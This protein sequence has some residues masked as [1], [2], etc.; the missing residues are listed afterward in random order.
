M[1]LLPTLTLH[2]HYESKD[3]NHLYVKYH[4]N[5]V[6]LTHKSQQVLKTGDHLE[7]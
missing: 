1:S 2:Q 3:W 5:S 6:N 7:D 4:Q